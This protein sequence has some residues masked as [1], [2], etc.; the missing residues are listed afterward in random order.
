MIDCNERT[1]AVALSEHADG[2]TKVRLACGETLQQ[3]LLKAVGEDVLVITTETGSS[4]V[5]LG[6]IDEVALRP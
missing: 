5:P 4:V 6:N 1:L 2:G 3:G